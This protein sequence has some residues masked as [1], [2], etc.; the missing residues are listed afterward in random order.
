MQVNTTPKP[1]TKPAAK[2]VN[3]DS[4]PPQQSGCCIAP[5]SD[6]SSKPRPEGDRRRQAGTFCGG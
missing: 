2:L 4:K 1:K 3:K 5:T 6:P